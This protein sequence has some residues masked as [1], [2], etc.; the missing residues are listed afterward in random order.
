MTRCGH[1]NCLETPA[2]RAMRLQPEAPESPN[3][4]GVRVV[5]L[6]AV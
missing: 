4:E 2:L 3:S 1:D 6:E 5:Q